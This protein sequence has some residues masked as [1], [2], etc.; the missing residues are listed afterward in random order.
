MDNKEKKQLQHLFE[1]EKKAEQILV[2]KNDSV[3]LDMRRNWDRESLRAL[4]KLR[5]GQKVWTIFGPN[6]TKLTKEKAKEI[7]E[8]DMVDANIEINKLRSD[9][10]VKVNELR[11]LEYQEKYTGFSLN[12][13]TNKELSAMKQVWN[14]RS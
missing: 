14:E 3:S 6:I 4:D 12:A 11:D 10:K 1:V 7:L 8:Q 13:L 2:D 9:M 5:D